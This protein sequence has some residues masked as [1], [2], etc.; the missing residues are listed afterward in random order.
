MSADKSKLI[1]LNDDEVMRRKLLLDGDGVGDD[2]RLN[3]V[4]K[5]FIKWCLTDDETLED[6]VLNYE[7]ILSTL[8]QCE[9]SMT[10]SEQTLRMISRE[11]ENYEDLYRKIDK[12]IE[13]CQQKLVK[14][15]AELSEAKRVRKNKCEYESMAVLIGRHPDRTDTMKQLQEL[16]KEIRRLQKTK[17][18]IQNKLEKRRKQFQVL[19]G[20]AQQ[21]NQILNAEEESESNDTTTALTVV[22]SAEA[23]ATT[24]DDV[25]DDQKMDTI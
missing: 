3:V 16:E 20:A 6:R 17:T 19:L 15:K 13:D 5:Q 12:S 7:R 14:C 18:D 23:A 21:L 8:S 11:M 25:T 9:L 1:Q 4:L 10:K 24:T 2:R 22:S